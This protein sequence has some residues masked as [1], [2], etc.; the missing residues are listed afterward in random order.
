MHGS[1][2]PEPRARNESVGTGLSSGRDT[3]QVGRNVAGRDLYVYEGPAYPRLPYAREVGPFVTFYNRVFVGREA[4]LAGI[5]AFSRRSWPSY[6]LVEAP[7]GY[8]KTALVAQ[9]LSRRRAGFWG[10]AGPDIVYFFIREE[11]GRASPDSFLQAV[12]SQLLDLLGERGGVPTDLESQRSQL[13]WLWE[14]AAKAARPERPLLLLVDGLDE[15]ARGAMNIAKLLPATLGE[16][17]GVVVTSRP[18]PEPLTQVPLE[19]PLRQ[20]AVIRL[21]TLE[22]ADIQLL[23]KVEGCSDATAAA[24]AD[25]VLS[26]SRGEPLLARFVGQDVAVDGERALADLERDRPQG[27]KEYFQKQFEQ[28]DSRAEAETTWQVLG[29]LLVAHGAMTV[30]EMAAVLGLPLRQ[31][32]VA[33]QPIERFLIGRD[34]LELMHLELRS[35]VSGQFGPGEQ[36][37]FRD[38]VLDWGA[39]FAAADWPE[40]TPDYLLARYAAHLRE[41][42]RSEELFRL[43]D[44]RWMELKAGR[45][46]SHRSF[47]QDVL[48]A[49]DA[50]GSMTPPDLVQE[51]CCSLVYATLGSLAGHVPPELLAILTAGG[52]F[53]TAEDYAALLGDP[54]ARCLAYLAVSGAALRSGQSRE[55]GAAADQALL[56]AKAV[57]DSTRKADLLARATGA[58]RAADAGGKVLAGANATGGA[59]EPAATFRLAITLAEAGRGEQ[60]LRTARAIEDDERRSLALEKTALLLAGS[61]Q[62]KYAVRAALAIEEYW[63]RDGTLADVIDVLVREELSEQAAEHVLAAAVAIEERGR[64]SQTLMKAAD[65]FAK[66]GR[67]EH[68]SRAADALAGLSE[69]ATTLAFVASALADGGYDEQAGDEAEKAVACVLDIE[70]LGERAET[71]ARMAGVLPRGHAERVAI[72]AEEAVAQAGGAED[73]GPRIEVLAHAA[74][75]L[76]AAG[77]TESAARAAE[78]ALAEEV[79][80]VAEVRGI[81]EW[82]RDPGSPEARAFRQAY[83]PDIVGLRPDPGRYRAQ[84]ALAGLALALAQA[85]LVDLAVAVADVAGDGW[86]RVELLTRMAGVSA[87]AGRAGAADVVTERV[88]AVVH[89]LPA[90][91]GG[92]VAFDHFAFDDFSSRSSLAHRLAL[93]F[94]DAG[95]PEQAWRAA[96]G[97]EDP[98]RKVDSLARVVAALAQGGR[99]ERAAEAAGEAVALLRRIPDR[100]SAP[101]YS[102]VPDHGGRGRAS[103]RLALTMA[104]TGLVEQ[105]LAL[106]DEVEAGKE[107][108]DIL[109]ETAQALAAVGQDEWAARAAD[110]AVAEADAI[111]DI[112]VKAWALVAITQTLMAA[113]LTE[114]WPTVAERAIGALQFVP[115][116][117]GE[118]WSAIEP[119]VE[120]SVRHVA[121]D[122]YW[123]LSKCEIVKALALLLATA[124]AGEQMLRAVRALEHAEKRDNL[125]ARVMSVR[126]ESGHVEDVFAAAAG[127]A[128]SRLRGEALARAAGVLA[129]ADSADAAARVAGAVDD[130]RLRAETLVMVADVLAKADRP[131]QA[132]RVAEQALG[133]ARPLEDTRWKVE[134]LAR[135]AAELGVAGTTE[136]AEFTMERALDAGKL[137]EQPSRRVEALTGV[138]TALIRM[139]K[140]AEAA[141]IAQQAYD[142]ADGVDQDHLRDGALANAASACI[143]AGLPEQSLTAAQRVKDPKRRAQVLSTIARGWADSGRTED[144]TAAATSALDLVADMRGGRRKGQVV[145]NAAHALAR[146]GDPEVVLGLVEEIDDPLIKT[147]ALAAL[148]GVFAE[149]GRPEQATACVRRAQ[150][151]G[152]GIDNPHRRA[153]ALVTVVGAC[154]RTA[155]RPQVLDLIDRVRVAADDMSDTAAKAR[156]LVFLVK[157]LAFAGLVDE[158]VE[159]SEPALAAVGRM[160]EPAAKAL[161]L[162]NLA[163][164]LSHA[165]RSEPALHTLRQ[166]LEAARLAGRSLFLQVL[167]RLAETYARIDRQ[168]DLSKIAARILEIEQWWAT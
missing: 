103:R 44:Q 66:A 134:A 79:R 42:N 40:D 136:Q 161:S 98:G 67:G 18:N 147:T 91:A 7:P 22:L 146:T 24:L 153:R 141:S 32:R 156:T 82:L 114:H 131:Q 46:H 14:R 25:R 166:S 167:S 155:P 115:V 90:V 77:R 124:G 62:G 63:R 100:A 15:M 137:V 65:L 20:A 139:G 88:F 104:Q 102:Y 165:G 81:S 29:L 92:R 83:D 125:L 41:A 119:S 64:R 2:D 54:K 126:A 19:H 23:L 10:D 75:A 13:L 132:L 80:A 47:A 53:T 101:Y 140:A 135:I 122:S 116:P 160:T 55:A 56:A 59:A 97:I 145:A 109:A 158:A 142:I 31:V 11:T 162:A 110:R 1:G 148:S 89:D 159:H 50:A 106:A 33:I 112:R 4:E 78:R 68:A 95:L 138:V 150:E 96:D 71:L 61:G 60:A 6:L 70:D 30:G 152:G 149:A 58:R 129:R 51:T 94:V 69:R 121:I 117:E 93:A 28:L 39:G 43:V 151:I 85:G 27:V 26:I 113:G 38:R 35:V 86:W 45:T 107:R 17:V 163:R 105:S 21:N 118:P 154:A 48:L 120:L 157:E 12:N 34:R 144:A 128:D 8:G 99:T 57:E 73:A 84:V 108:V 111:D 87:A 164:I 72:A 76:A 36:Q 52:Q 130:N 143:E 37:M 123:F 49:L 127:M 168:Q 16:H 133:V 5:R 74:A 3:V 9:L